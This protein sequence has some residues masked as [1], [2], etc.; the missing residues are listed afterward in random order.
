MTFN[1]GTINFAQPHSGS[2][3]EVNKVHLTHLF[4]EIYEIQ[5]NPELSKGDD[6]DSFYNDINQVVTKVKTEQSQRR[7]QKFM[8]ANTDKT[9]SDKV[10]DQAFF[11][12]LPEVPSHKNIGVDLATKVY[13]RRRLLSVKER[14]M[15]D[16]AITGFHQHRA[17]DYYIMTN[18]YRQ[19]W[20]GGFKRILN[21]IAPGKVFH[22]ISDVSIYDKCKLWCGDLLFVGFNDDSVYLIDLHHNLSKLTMH[23]SFLRLGIDLTFHFDFLL[24]KKV[25]IIIGYNDVVGLDSHGAVDFDHKDDEIV[26]QEAYDMGFGLVQVLDNGLKIGE[27]TWGGGGGFKPISLA[28]FE[29]KTQDFCENLYKSLA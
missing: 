26:R 6:E 17:H 29:E 10:L 1:P 19:L 15:V 21:N 7:E 22:I 12:G 9:L 13:N 4:R 28:F 16:Y 2:D 20:R 24:N 18:F 27:V 8:L 23:R 14:V 5:S 11:D 25:Y 3:E